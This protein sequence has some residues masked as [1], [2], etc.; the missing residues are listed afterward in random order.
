MQLQS[1][2]AQDEHNAQAELAFASGRAAYHQ[3]WVINA[4]PYIP[5]EHG[6]AS[7]LSGWLDAASEAHSLEADTVEHDM[8]IEVSRW[9]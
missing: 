9:Y 6:C 5:N 7:W 4:N 2:T 8:G 3:G 1:F